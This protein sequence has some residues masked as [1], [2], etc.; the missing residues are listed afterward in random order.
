[1]ASGMI[2]SQSNCLRPGKWQVVTNQAGTSPNRSVMTPTPKTIASVLT[3]YNGSRRCFK[4]SMAPAGSEKAWKNKIKMG[5]EI[6]MMITKVIA[7]HPQNRPGRSAIANLPD[8]TVRL[9]YW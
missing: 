6:S 9:L 2:N 8:R 1:M 5:M 4:L 7:F 3:R